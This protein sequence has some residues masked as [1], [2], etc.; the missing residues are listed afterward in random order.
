M[1][2]IAENKQYSLKLDITKNRAFLKIR[3][4]W[5]NKEDIPAYLK[6]WDEAINK[7]TP[8]FTL[9]TDAT[10]MVIHPGD[11][12]DVHSKA[13]KKVIDAGIRKVAELH[14]SGGQ[15]MQLD[16]VSKETG[17]PKKNFDNEEDAIKWLD[18]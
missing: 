3:G 4:F 1:I 6:D 2:T 7:L 12:R 14:N 16:S 10:E 5:R 17:M 15:E 18:E 11:V 8:G 9:L 13:Q